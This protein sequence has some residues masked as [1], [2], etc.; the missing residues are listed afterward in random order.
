MAETATKTEKHSFQ[1]EVGRLL[2]IVANALYSEREIFLRELISNAADACDRLRYQ[3]LTEPALLDG[4]AEFQIDL[5]FDEDA[6][7]LTISDNGSGMTKEELVGNL[8]TIARSGTSNFVSQLSGDEK[9]DVSLIG[10]FGV[11][12]YAAFMVADK[13]DV[14][15]RRAGEDTAWQWIS[16]GK[17]DFT[18]E[19]ASRDA[20]GTT[21]TLHMKEDAAEFLSEPRIANIVKTYSDHIPFPIKIAGEGED[22]PKQLNAAAALWTRNKSEIDEQQYKE[23]YHHVSHSFDDPWATLHFRA[24]GVIEYAGLIYIP[25]MR[26]FDLFHPDRKSK[27]K[28]Y[29]KRVFITDECEDL[30]PSWLRFLRGV[31]DSQDLPLNVSREMLQNNPVVAKIRSGLVKRVVGEL[32]KKAEKEAD[33]YTT[34]WDAF[35]PVLKE[36]VYESPEHRD[37][38]M[39]LMRFKSTSREGWVSLA[40]YV[41]DMKEGQ[42]AIYYISGDDQDT[43]S[44]SPQLEGFAAK[45]IEVLYMTDPVDEFWIPS[46]G[47]FDGKA[48]KSVTRGGADLSKIKGAEKED[49]KK[50]D[51]SAD[52]KAATETVDA[53]VTALREALGDSVKDVRK[54]DRLTSSP[55]CLVAD[56]GEMD[57]HLERLLKQHKQLEQGAP[58]ILEI[59]PGHV[60][61]KALAGNAA[62][63]VKDA[64]YLL[65]DQARIMEGEPLPDPAGFAQ[66]MT[67]VMTKAMG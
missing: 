60:L 7:T 38:L 32:S 26:P 66:R 20:R 9:K 36:G 46:V 31:I 8:G 1:A 35:G 52:D 3:A 21:I 18:V 37:E 62:G 16:D 64:A 19:P 5:S 43:L 29:V 39:K 4:G 56:D 11:G 40:D 14:I 13:V 33:T 47:E 22:Y 55:C 10:Q 45:G 49:E 53:L 61:I 65:L 57:M 51:D 12:F 54:S 6:K 34:F 50:D 25:T 44:R 28:L 30:V 17:G 42:E 58:R 48:L 15:S 59:N 63:D 27:L 24:E 41:A 2:D 67:S 23:F